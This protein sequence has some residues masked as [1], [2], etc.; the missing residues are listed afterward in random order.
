M[1][2]SLH[3]VSPPSSHFSGG[4]AFLA[5]RGSSHVVVL[6]LWLKC[7]GGD[8]VKKYKRR[9]ENS[10]ISAGNSQESRYPGA[11]A[12][13]LTKRCPEKQN[14]WPSSNHLGSNGLLKKPSKNIGKILTKLRGPFEVNRRERKWDEEKREENKSVSSHRDHKEQN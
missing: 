7:K 3:I 12:L 10:T 9:H 4:L 8:R 14:V 6:L 5:R 13:A 1:Q 2:L 11:I